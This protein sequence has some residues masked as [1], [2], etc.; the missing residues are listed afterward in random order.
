MNHRAKTTILFS[1][2]DKI[3][4]VHKNNVHNHKMF[5]DSASGGFAAPVTHT[6][7]LVSL[8]ICDGLQQLGLRKRNQRKKEV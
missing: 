4:I 3:A 2:R 7:F 8:Y 1:F 6:A 5:Y